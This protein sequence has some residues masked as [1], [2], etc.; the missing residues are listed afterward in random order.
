LIT[1]AELKSISNG[2][3]QI[4]A[5]VLITQDKE[6]LTN[7]DALILPELELSELPCKIDQI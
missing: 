1:A 7:A 5:E 4:G 2:F 3:Q 6:E